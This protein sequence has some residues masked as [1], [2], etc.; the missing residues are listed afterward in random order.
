MTFEISSQDDWPYGP[1]VGLS[2]EHSEL[3]PDSEMLHSV[4]FGWPA[5]LSGLKTIIESPDIF[6]L[7]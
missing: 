3:E 5:V 6:S 4:T 7:G 2:V 1:W